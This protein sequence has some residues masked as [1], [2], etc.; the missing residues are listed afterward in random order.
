M[1]FDRIIFMLLI[2]SILLTY[3]S[4]SERPP[5][6]FG[7]KGFCILSARS[8]EVEQH[9]ECCLSNGHQTTTAQLLW[10]SWNTDMGCPNLCGMLALNLFVLIAMDFLIRP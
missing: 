2:N 6:L 7:G 4:L 3:H 1:N 5:G 9:F 10:A 8:A